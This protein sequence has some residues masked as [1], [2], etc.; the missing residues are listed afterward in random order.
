MAIILIE[1][2]STSAAEE[3]VT[4]SE[5]GEL[6]GIDLGT[7]TKASTYSKYVLLELTA[8]RSFNLA[9]AAPE[10]DVTIELQENDPPSFTDSTSEAKSWYLRGK[11]P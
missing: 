3:I 4:A 11:L 8:T 5:T 1:T 2:S 7:T 6:W 9:N 10:D